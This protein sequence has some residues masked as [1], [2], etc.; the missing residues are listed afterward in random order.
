M[1]FVPIIKLR[2][3]LET[4]IESKMTSE[5]QILELKASLDKERASRQESV[6]RSTKEQD[7]EGST[8]TSDDRLNV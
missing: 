6:Q 4:L 8:H 5:A 3:R 1:R 7:R 2:A